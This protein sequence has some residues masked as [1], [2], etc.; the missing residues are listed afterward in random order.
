M[1]VSKTKIAV[2]ALAMGLISP[3]LFAQSMLQNYLD[4]AASIIPNQFSLSLYEEAKYND[5]IHN[6]SSDEEG[7]LIFK[8]GASAQ[9]YRTKGNLTYGL[10]GDVSYDW[11]TKDSDDLSTLNWN[12]SPFING[13]FNNKYL[14]GLMISLKSRSVYEPYSKTDTR[15]VKH[16]ENGIGLAYDYSRQERWGVITTADYT[17]KYYPQGDRNYSST[18]NNKYNLS[19]APYY[20]FSEK[21]RTGIQAAYEKVDYRNDK[22]YDDSTSVK[23]TGFVD[24]RANMFWNMTAYAGMERYSFDGISRDSN[25]DRDWEPVFEYVLRYVPSKDWMFSYNLRYEP[26][27][28]TETARGLRQAWN[29][30]LRVSWNATSKINFTQS[31]GVDVSDERNCD[32]DTTEFKYSLRANYYATENLTV[33]AGYEYDDVHF[34]YLDDSDYHSNEFILGLRWSM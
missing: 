11:Y 19:I 13:S 18:T 21:V 12:L 3:S 28:G 7:S 5:N 4:V 27:Y 23:I 10:D 32:E 34:K 26:E 33:Y 22:K 17:N 14:Q 16:Y 24:Y 6:S 30:S 8:T 29:N 2:L 9:I 1:K 20:K 25:K 15:Y 31:I